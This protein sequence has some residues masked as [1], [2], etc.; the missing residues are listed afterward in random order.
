M[1]LDI[2]FSE[3]CEN[4]A[5]LEPILKCGFPCAEINNFEIYWNGQI[6]V[7]KFVDII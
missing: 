3:L 1:W 4:S 5:V 2:S 6:H 7:T